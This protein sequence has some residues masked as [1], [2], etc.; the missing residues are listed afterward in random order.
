[1]ES[2]ARTRS[3]PLCKEQEPRRSRNYLGRW[4]WNW[5]QR[6]FPIHP[7]WSRQHVFGSINGNLGT[8]S[9]PFFIKLK[10]SA[11]FATYIGVRMRHWMCSGLHHLLLHQQ[12]GH[13]LCGPQ[14]WLWFSQTAQTT[15][16]SSE[17]I[18][19]C[20]GFAPGSGSCPRAD[21]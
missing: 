20:A 1:V 6:H 18:G 3:L 7:S 19:A 12:Y 2:S 8:P 13:I 9:L 21:T 10:G 16:S 17:G 4:Q 5:N 15:C 11:H 14:R